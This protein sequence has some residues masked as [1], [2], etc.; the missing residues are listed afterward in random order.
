MREAPVGWQCASCVTQ[1]ARISPTV[2]PLRRAPG[3][4]GST[5]M[6]PVV[7][8]LILVNAGVYIWELT[9]LDNV[10]RRFEMWPFAVHY[11]HQYYRLITAA[12]LHA[13]FWHIA[14]NM[15]SLAIIGPPIEAELG[16]ARFVSIYFLSAL[17]GSTASYLISNPNLGGV[18]A[19]GAIFGLMGAYFVL[20]RRRRWD[21]SAITFLVV[22][23][24][25]LSFTDQ[26]I[27]WRAHL[28]GLIVGAVVC[29]GLV[30]GAD[31]PNPTSS[32]LRQ[33]AVVVGMGAL[34]VVLVQLPPG[35]V[36]L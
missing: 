27:D 28:G 16:E 15:A 34:L 9:N 21:M 17:G 6:T 14:F 31:D 10:L 13:S 26:A 2:R 1:G 4:L 36:N 5:R 24:L 29:L 8:V 12:F 7:A 23:N 30:S 35:H 3:R 32:T 33:V 11:Y 25:I 19:S 18:G 22:G 20:A